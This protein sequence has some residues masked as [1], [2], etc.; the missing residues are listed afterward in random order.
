MKYSGTLG[1]FREFKCRDCGTEFDRYFPH[2]ETREAFGIVQCLCC[3]GQAV[4]V[5]NPSVAELVIGQFKE[6][7]MVKPEFRS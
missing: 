1:E 2:F 7:A 5:E 3:R 6:N 4:L